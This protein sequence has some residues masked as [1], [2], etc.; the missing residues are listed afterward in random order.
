MLSLTIVWETFYEESVLIWLIENAFSE[1][2]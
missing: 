1:I 2:A